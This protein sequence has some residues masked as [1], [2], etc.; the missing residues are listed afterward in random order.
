MFQPLA[1]AQTCSINLDWIDWIGSSESSISSTCEKLVRGH[2]Y[3]FFLHFA[4]VPQGATP[5]QDE[6]NP[7]DLSRSSPHSAPSPHGHIKPSNPGQ[8]KPSDSAL[9]VLVWVTRTTPADALRRTPK[10]QWREELVN[11][12]G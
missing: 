8:G 4:S 3:I 2:H 9:P 6:P 10:V 7:P 5:C 12:L 11:A 1:V